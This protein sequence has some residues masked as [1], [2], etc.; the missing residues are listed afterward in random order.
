MRVLEFSA[1]LITLALGFAG[2][3]PTSPTAPETRPALLAALDGNWIMIGDVLGKPVKYS[4]SV[5]PIL[6]RTFTELHM[7]DLQQPP[8]YEAR[9]FIAHDKGS[10]QIVVHWLDVFGGGICVDRSNLG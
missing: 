7:V 9:I 1:I 6:A 8:Q 3:A 2:P 10:G 5:S 4:L